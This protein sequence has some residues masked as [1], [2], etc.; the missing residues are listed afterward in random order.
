MTLFAPNGHAMLPPRDF[1]IYKCAKMQLERVSVTTL[2]MCIILEVV[3]KIPI[4]LPERTK[5]LNIFFLMS[6][7]LPEQPIEN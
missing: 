1:D 3:L 4:S 5:L 2:L 6:Q 7:L